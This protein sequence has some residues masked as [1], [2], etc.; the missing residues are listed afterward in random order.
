M[1]HFFVF[2]L[3]S[4]SVTLPSCFLC[5]S[6]FFCLL[7][8]LLLL[9]IRFH[10]LHL[11]LLPLHLLFI[12]GPFWKT[13]ANR[14]VFVYPFYFSLKGLSATVWMLLMQPQ[15]TN[16]KKNTSVSSVTFSFGGCLIIFDFSAQKRKLFT[17]LM[18]CHC[19]VGG[20]APL[21]PPNSEFSW[22]HGV[23]QGDSSFAEFWGCT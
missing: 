20:F 13:L 23:C 5:Y 19:W 4:F 18:T 6:S 14:R 17:S 3:F 11:L 9:L 16:W 21:S 22:Q 15:S 7:L 12:C 1:H 8:L 10:F 2:T